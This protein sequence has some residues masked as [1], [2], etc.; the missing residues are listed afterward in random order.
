MNNLLYK[1]ACDQIFLSPIVTTVDLIQCI[2][3]SYDFIIQKTRETIL[4][5]KLSHIYVKKTT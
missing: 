5:R 4:L 2:T 1:I 3:K